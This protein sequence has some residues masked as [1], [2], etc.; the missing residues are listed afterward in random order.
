[1]ASSIMKGSLRRKSDPHAALYSTDGK[2]IMPMRPGKTAEDHR[3]GA[4]ASKSERNARQA[5]Y[6]EAASRNQK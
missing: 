6:Q 5:A 2:A 1:M 4:W 3:S